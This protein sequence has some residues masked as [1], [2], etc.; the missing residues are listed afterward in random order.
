[1]PSA[2]VQVPKNIGRQR[3]AAPCT[4][5]CRDCSRVTCTS[6]KLQTCS[7]AY[8]TA[9]SFCAM[10]LLRLRPLLLLF[11]QLQDSFDRYPSLLRDN[12]IVLSIGHLYIRAH[13][14]SHASVQS[15]SGGGNLSHI[16]FIKIRLRELGAGR[17]ISRGRSFYCCMNP[18]PQIGRASC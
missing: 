15:L 9:F 4:L 2:S 8:I 14:S 7:T 16:P 17:G 10:V 1:R 18:P 3:P 6:Y 12:P 13:P 11:N 5:N